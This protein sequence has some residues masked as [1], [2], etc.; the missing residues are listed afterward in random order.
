MQWWLSIVPFCKFS[1][2]WL[3]HYILHI[4][5][6]WCNLKYL[7]LVLSSFSL[8]CLEM[9]NRHAY[10]LQI[11]LIY[12]LKV[13]VHVRVIFFDVAFPST[14]YWN[15]DKKSATLD[16]LKLLGSCLL[17]SERCKK[18]AN[19]MWIWIIGFV[20]L[21]FTSKQFPIY[22]CFSF[23]LISNITISYIHQ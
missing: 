6:P 2:T 7:I 18:N 23:E 14:T 1:S 10:P 20:F 21:P 16:E 13:L 17:E 12:E 8:V 22:N 19:R 11:K 9:E 4:L 3:G 15:L 5:L